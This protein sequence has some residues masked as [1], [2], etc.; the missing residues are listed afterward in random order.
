MKRT[1]FALA[2]LAAL[3][4]GLP[5]VAQGAAEF[6]KSKTIR[7][8]VGFNPGGSYDFYAR[9]A[10]EMLKASIPGLDAAIVENRPGAGGLMATNFFYNQASK[11]GL[12]LAV[13]PDTIANTQLMEPTNSKWD[14]TR[15]NYIGS[16]A[17]VNSAVLRRGAAPAKSIA[18][19]KKIEVVV[20]CSGKN[21]QS[22]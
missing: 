18:D 15:I 4:A 1:I 9:L 16:F 17:P 14:V 5:A 8:M 21:A 3:S 13:L 20:G 11:D 6:Y 10:A 19:M 22:Y 2:S 7:V 12:V